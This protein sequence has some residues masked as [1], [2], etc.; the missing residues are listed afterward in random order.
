M[1]HRSNQEQTV[2]ITA[3]LADTSRNS[4]MRSITSRDVIQEYAELTVRVAAVH[5]S[6]VG[7][8]ERPTGVTL[9]Q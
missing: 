6:T 5:G 1:I 7:D 9:W 3:A 2:M 8:R 4:E